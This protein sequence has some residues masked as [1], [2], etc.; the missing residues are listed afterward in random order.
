VGDQLAVE[1]ARLRRRVAELEAAEAEHKRSEQVRAAMLAISQAAHEAGDLD[2]LFHT[3]HEIVGTLMPADNFYIALYDRSSDTLVFPYFV[4][5]HDVIT[6]PIRAGRG[7]TEYIVRTGEALLA[8]SE[9]LKRLADEGEIEP[10]GQVAASYLGAPLKRGDEVIGVLSVQSYDPARKYGEREREILEFVS[11]QVA[12]AIHHKRADAALLES[13][14]QYR[15]VVED[16]PL[17]V[18]R[19]QPDGTISFVNDAYCRYFGRKRE[20]LVGK[21][22]MMLIPEEDRDFV[23]NQFSSLTVDRPKVTYEHRVIAADGRIRW[24]RWTDRAIFDEQ[25]QLVS[26]Q[27]I[28]EDITEQRQLEK[29]LQQARNAEIVARLAGGMAHYYNNLL[30]A[31]VGFAELAMESLPSGHQA[32]EDIQQVIQSADRAAKLTQQL[33][34]FARKQILEPRITDLNAIAADTVTALRP[35]IPDNVELVVRQEPDLWAVK[36][37]PYRIQ[38]S[39]MAL[40]LNSCDAMP[41]GGVLTLETANVT[42]DEEYA[43]RHPGIKPGDYVMVTV[44]DTGSGMSDEVKEHLFEPFFTTKEVGEG[45]GLGLATVYGTI[46]QHLGHIYVLSEPNQGTTV[47]IYLPR[48]DTS[49][50]QEP[51]LD[52]EHDLPQGNETILLAE[53]EPL[54]RQITARLLRRQG[55]TVLEASGGEEALNVVEKHSGAI[56]LLLADAVMPRMSGKEL[57][58]R[59]REAYPDLAVLF[60][61]GYREDI[62]ARRGILEP[63]TAFL[64]KPFDAAV[65]MRTVRQVLDSRKTDRH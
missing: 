5:E 62:V 65:L 23:R 32:A 24:Q 29:Q 9:T 26:F 38:Q 21:N 6:A 25:G 64:Q 20:E 41:Q 8:D 44:T 51:H 3:I 11:E 10:R 1:L 47:R 55:Y 43:R 13:A 60:T 34:A 22:F 39:L 14:Q 63:G 37:D 35:I 42:V 17:L 16:L 4:D 45:T 59:L 50:D 53:D 48:A 58:N 12:M 19:F 31:I 56:H 2:Q 52:T 57:A 40:G 33:L 30:T 15:A 7:V 28:G 27:S 54:V 49:A 46:K 36:V 61:S 18:C